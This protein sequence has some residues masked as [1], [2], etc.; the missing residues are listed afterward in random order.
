MFSI[1]ERFLLCFCSTAQ[2][3]RIC[4]PEIRYKNVTINEFNIDRIRT[5][6]MKT[7][8][9]N[10]YKTRIIIYRYTVSNSL[11]LSPDDVIYKKLSNI[12]E[13]RV[14]AHE[15]K[16]L[17]NSKSDCALPWGIKNYYQIPMLCAIEEASAYAAGYLYGE[18]PRNRYEMLMAAYNGIHLLSNRMAH[19]FPKYADIIAEYCGYNSQDTDY[20]QNLIKC[21][22]CKSVNYSHLFHK[23]A[24]KYMTFGNYKLFDIKHHIP[25]DVRVELTKLRTTCEEATREHLRQYLRN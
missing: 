15:M 16:H 21:I 25:R 6:F 14:L 18:S 8:E 11:N 9:A 2:P 17:Q 4:N 13:K 24:D 23:M 1:Y 3:V 12:S 10:R 20:K 5:G 19:Y 7:G 22:N